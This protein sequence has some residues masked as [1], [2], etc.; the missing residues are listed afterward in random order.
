MKYG[1]ILIMPIGFTVWFFSVVICLS[2]I[3]LQS[4]GLCDTP[5]ACAIVSRSRTPVGFGTPTPENHKKNIYQ[6]IRIIENAD[7]FRWDFFV[8]SDVSMCETDLQ[9]RVF[10]MS[11]DPPVRNPRRAVQAAAP[12]SGVSVVRRMS[13]ANRCLGNDGRWGITSRSDFSRT[14]YKIQKYKYKIMFFFV[15]IFVTVSVTRHMSETNRRWAVG[16]EEMLTDGEIC[17]RREKWLFIWC[18]LIDS[19]CRKQTVA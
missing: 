19:F 18:F 9:F 1:E 8:C 15:L 3:I 6:T 11:H 14:K 16:G 2:V 4:R 7:A 17:G 12:P 10:T 5:G 13:K